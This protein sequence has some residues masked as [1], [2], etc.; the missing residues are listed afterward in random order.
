[1]LDGLDGRG[2]GGRE[3]LGGSG[4]SEGEN[5]MTKL[6]SSR[7]RRSVASMHLILDSVT[8]ALSTRI[9]TNENVSL[10]SGTKGASLK[11]PEGGFT[12]PFYRTL[13]CHSFHAY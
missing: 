8:T 4:A 3:R 1:M 11:P 9:K 13:E 12:Q 2:D 5:A 7:K 10:M 6:H